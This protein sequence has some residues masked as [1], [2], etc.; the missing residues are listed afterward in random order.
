MSLPSGDELLVP[1]DKV[2]SI[3]LY[4]SIRHA[5]LIYSTAVTFPLPAL[6]GHFHK[7]AATLQQLL[8]A[9]KFDSCWRHYPKTLLWILVLGGIAASDTKERDWFVRSLSIVAKILKIGT[10]QEASEI[11]ESFLWLESACGPGGRIL[12]AEVT[13][14][15]LIR[16]RS[17]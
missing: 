2:K 6:S 14:G 5:A 8:E 13:R 7:L 4:E 16:S 17:E 1:E 11:V 9:S 15:R 10:W 3:A 12:W